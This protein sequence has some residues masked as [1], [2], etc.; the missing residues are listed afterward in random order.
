MSAAADALEQ[1]M[2]QSRVRVDAAN[3]AMFDAIAACFGALSR[4]LLPGKEVELVRVGRKADAGV[5]LR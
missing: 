1:C 4:E 3:E 5:Q 2:Q